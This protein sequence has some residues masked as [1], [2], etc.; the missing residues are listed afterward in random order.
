MTGVSE[1]QGSESGISLTPNLCSYLLIPFSSSPPILE[2]GSGNVNSLEAFI[3]YL[4]D[5]CIV[6]GHLPP[7][8]Y[9]FSPSPTA[10]KRHR[11]R[12]ALMKENI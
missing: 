10:V 6:S 11:G 12:A 7:L 3:I 1:K 5:C 2:N 9:R 8:R 4:W